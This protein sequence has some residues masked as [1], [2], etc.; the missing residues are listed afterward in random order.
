MAV[1]DITRKFLDEF[2]EPN[3]KENG[4]VPVIYLKEALKKAVG[5]Y[6]KGQ[7]DFKFLISLSADI[8]LELTASN[9]TDEKFFQ[10]VSDFEELQDVSEV[11]E[12]KVVEKLKSMVK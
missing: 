7:R 2:T 5:E 11:K 12:K 1:E 3:R 9:D 10:F 8:R 6:E 4:D